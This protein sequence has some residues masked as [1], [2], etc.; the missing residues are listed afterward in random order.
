MIDFVIS[1]IVPILLYILAAL[2]MIIIPII[3]VQPK[4]KSKFIQNVIYSVFITFGVIAITIM[5]LTLVGMAHQ[6]QQLNELG[7]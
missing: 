1:H 3:I 7:L 5:L 6:L 2:G 4:P